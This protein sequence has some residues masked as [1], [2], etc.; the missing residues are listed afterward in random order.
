[1][2]SPESTIAK[3]LVANRGGI[4]IRAFRAAHE[5]GM[6]TSPPPS[7]GWSPSTSTQATGSNPVRRSPPSRQ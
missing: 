6:A 4:A 7:R 2:P 3:I 5:L 1:M